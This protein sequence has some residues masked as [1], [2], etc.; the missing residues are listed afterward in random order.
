[1]EKKTYHKRKINEKRNSRK[2]GKKDKNKPYK[3]RNR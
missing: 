3:N 2:T 1:M